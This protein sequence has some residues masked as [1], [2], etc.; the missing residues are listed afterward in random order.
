[1]LNQCATV[2]WKWKV[3]RPNFHSRSQNDQR[4]YLAIYILIWN[5]FKSGNSVSLSCLK[6]SSLNKVR[7][8]FQL[9][10]LSKF[11]FDT[12]TFSLFKYIKIT[13]NTLKFLNTFEE[14]PQMLNKCIKNRFKE[15]IKMF[16]PPYGWKHDLLFNL[17]HEY[18]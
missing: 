12:L 6:H 16:L 14:N 13:L 7:M 18:F 2:N 9:S 4:V 5:E 8:L 3:K 10:Q 1:M 17:I 11:P 15:K